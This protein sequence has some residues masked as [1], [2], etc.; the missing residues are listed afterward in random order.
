MPDDGRDAARWTATLAAWSS[1][2]LLALATCLGVS[3]VVSYSVRIDVVGD[4]ASRMDPA[5]YLELTRITET[6]QGF[7]LGA[8]AV[9]M[10]AIAFGASA[11]SWHRRAKAG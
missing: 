3:A 10:A 9:A 6:E 1:A 8:L 4:R 2:G 7:L 5:L 11:Y